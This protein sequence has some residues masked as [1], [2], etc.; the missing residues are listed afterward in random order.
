MS[1]QPQA[2]EAFE[3]SSFLAYKLVAEAGAWFEGSIIKELSSAKRYTGDRM[4]G[5]S[6]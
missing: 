2:L 5:V 1:I 6:G 4:G 3:H